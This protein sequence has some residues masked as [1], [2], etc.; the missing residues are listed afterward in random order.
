M[1]KTVI[2]GKISNLHLENFYT[3]DISNISR[4]DRK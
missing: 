3:V 4:N 2:G 1:G